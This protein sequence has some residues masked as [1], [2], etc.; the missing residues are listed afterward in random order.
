MPEEFE[1]SFLGAKLIKEYFDGIK[2][3]IKFV[4]AVA[5]T[6]KHRTIAVKKVLSNFPIISVG[7][8]SI[9]SKSVKL[10]PSFVEAWNEPTLQ[11]QAF[12]SV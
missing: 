6:I 7:F 12:E 4:E 9:L 11:V 1:L 8:V 2:F 5:K 3:A 10:E